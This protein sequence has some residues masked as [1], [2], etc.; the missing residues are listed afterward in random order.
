MKF[1]F[2][3]PK[4]NFYWNTIKLILICLWMLFCSAGMSSWDRAWTAKLKIFTMWPFTEKVCQKPRVRSS[5]DYNSYMK[6]PNIN[7]LKQWSPTL[8]ALQK[9]LACSA[10]RPPLLPCTTA[11]HPA[12]RYLGNLYFHV[13][14]VSHMFV[15]T[16]ISHLILTIVQWPQFYRWGNWGSQNEGSLLK[17]YIV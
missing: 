12:A 10:G 16:Y 3:C 9:L 6:K 14:T 8:A 5:T 2:K 15:F 4:I 1:K 7:Q 11:V 17:K 13:H